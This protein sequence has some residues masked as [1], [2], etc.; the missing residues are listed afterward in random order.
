MR[1]AYGRGAR[2]RP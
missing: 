2:P 1:V